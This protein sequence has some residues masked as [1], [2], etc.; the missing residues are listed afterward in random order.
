M[1]PKST[2]ESEVNIE[3]ASEPASVNHTSAAADTTPD[4]A[5]VKGVCPAAPA[6]INDDSGFAGDGGHDLFKDS[7][8]FDGS[9]Q[10]SQRGLAATG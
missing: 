1:N 5:V 8:E 3:L 9:H 2:F 6:A 4:E 7:K 10:R